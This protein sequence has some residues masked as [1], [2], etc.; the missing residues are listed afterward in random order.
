METLL[1][2]SAGFLPVPAEVPVFTSHTLPEVPPAIRSLF[3][4]SS[5]NCNMKTRSL[6]EK[7]HIIQADS[8]T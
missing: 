1:N 6:W 8:Q 3:S 4:E 7:N 5:G 2:N